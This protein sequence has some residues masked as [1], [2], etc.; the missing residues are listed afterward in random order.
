MNLCQADGLDALSGIFSEMCN[1]VP[2]S[3]YI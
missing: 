3:A 1:L 2:N